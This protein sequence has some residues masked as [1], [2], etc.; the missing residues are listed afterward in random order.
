VSL[1]PDGR[2]AEVFSF[3][4]VAAYDIPEYGAFLKVKAVAS[5]INNNI[6]K[7]YGIAFTFA[8]KL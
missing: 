2:R 1:P 7:S 8:K 4:P 6:V 5:E 3:G